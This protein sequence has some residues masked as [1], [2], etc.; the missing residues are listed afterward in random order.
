VIQVGK[1]SAVIAD[2]LERKVREIAFKR[3][4]GKRGGLSEIVQEAL[5][6]YIEEKVFKQKSSRS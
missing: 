2:D 5:E 4:G 3:R 6:D 1:I